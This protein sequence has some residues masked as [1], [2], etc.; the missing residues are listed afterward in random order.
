[1]NKT[2]DDFFYVYFTDEA[3]VNPDNVLLSYILRERGTRY[4]AENI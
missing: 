3:H 2:I 4:D 1:M